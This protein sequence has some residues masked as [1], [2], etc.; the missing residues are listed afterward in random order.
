MKLLVVVD[1][2]NDFIDGA[3]GTKEAQAIVKPIA[4]YIKNFDG[5]VVFTQDTH[6]SNYLS[7]Q[8]G[9]NL[10]VEHC[11][12]MTEGW[13]IK[14]ELKQ[15]ATSLPIDVY[16]KDT[17]GCIDLALDIQEFDRDDEIYLCGVCT[18]ICVITNAMVIKTVNPEVKITVLKDLC[19]GTCPELHN[20]ALKLMKKS[21]QVNVI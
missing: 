2:Q 13:F 9:K 7:T 11:I 21:L 4:E 17:F 3:L 6:Y 12:F 1:M 20:D 10:P 5:D 16:S 19:A 18:D 15:A 8:E 14:E